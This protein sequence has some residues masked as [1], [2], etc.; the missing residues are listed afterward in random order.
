MSSR[1]TIPAWLADK[2]P[3]KWPRKPAFHLSGG[4]VARWRKPVLMA[5]SCLGALGLGIG[6][7][8]VTDGIPVSFPAF[9]AGGELTAEV[10]QETFSSSVEEESS[11]PAEVEKEAA[12]EV[13][14]EAPA[15]GETVSAVSEPAP[16]HTPGW[17]EEEGLTR[18]WLEDGTFARGYTEIDGEGYYFD[19]NGD[20]QTGLVSDADGIRYFDAK[21]QMVVGDVTVNGVQLSFGEDGFIL[22]KA[23]M[24]VPVILQNDELPNGCEITS[25]TEVLQ[26]N[27]F[28]VSH[29][30]MVEYLPC[31]PIV[32]QNGEYYTA[33]PEDAYIGDPSTDSGWYCFEGPIVE[34]ANAYL[35]EVESPLRAHKV[36]GADEE[37]LLSYLQQ[38][39]PVI[40]WVTQQ[41][42]DVRR[43]GYTW[44]LPDGEVYH[45]YGG[46]H[47]VALSGMDV[48]A[49]T[50]TL[51]DPIY[52]EWEAKLDRFMEIYEGMGS[53]AVIV[54]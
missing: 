52:G 53:R 43:T 25:L 19:E 26:Y 35:R 12:V 15:E 2:L 11:A 30:E 47:C 18:Y 45:P 22:S 4:A 5:G 37:E 28:S 51:T 10:S 31:E 36:S 38:G 50:V 13:E 27:G 17:S 33:Y 16:L 3:S 20:M 54:R 39:N 46:L 32:Y 14:K 29:T 40:V 48:E 21:G 34:A 1:S 49:G 44:I 6:L 7:F 42:A 24:E 23:Q 8:F 41:L 9:A